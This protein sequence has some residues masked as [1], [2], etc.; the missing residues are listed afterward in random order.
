MKLFQIYFDE[1]QLA[2]L[3]FE[4]VHNPR[5][6]IFFENE[7][8]ADLEPKYNN[9]ENDYFGVLSHKFRKKIE[10]MTHF[11]GHFRNHLNGKFNLDVLN[12]KVY[13]IHNGSEVLNLMKFTPHDPIALGQVIHPKLE[14][15]FKE[16]L[17]CIGFNWSPTVYEH[18]FYC[19]YFIARSDIY[20]KYVSEM[21]APAIEVM[22]K[23]PELMEDAKYPRRF[24]A[25]LMIE[26]GVNFWPYHPF[27][28]ERLFSYFV[29]LYGFK[30]TYY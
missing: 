26:L 17:G 29:H 18:N 1:S 23:M 5:C 30:V 24:P 4:P 14:Q 11:P 19:N 12:S 10:Q 22:C 15:Y 7:V 16:V 25:N 27:I 20:R 3:D 8:I 13:D 6:T 9:I 21:L 2:G 28:C